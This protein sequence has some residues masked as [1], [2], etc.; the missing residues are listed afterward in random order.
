[1]WRVL[2][3]INHADVNLGMVFA[4]YLYQLSL[5]LGFMPNIKTCCQCNSVF[6]HAFIDD[7]TGELICH[8]C[9]SQS[10]LSLNKNCLIFLQKLENLHLD[11]I[12]SSMD[13]TIE[14][15]NAI[16]FL[17]IYTC[18]HLE[19]MDKVRSLEMVHQFLKQ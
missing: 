14:M 8:D 4:F 17:E 6:N 19:G 1:M 7:R 15:Y 9:C 11:D 12:R 18:I 16:H 10:K 5:Q 2:D 3:K 13:N